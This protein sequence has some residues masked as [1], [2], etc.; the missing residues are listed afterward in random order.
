ML[1]DK[2]L[3]K[4]QSILETLGLLSARFGDKTL[5]A[6]DHFEADLCAI[7]VG[8]EGDRCRLVYFSTYGHAPGR[9]YVELEL[10]PTESTV[11]PF[12]KGGQYS[13]VDFETLV[14]L[15]AE[16]LSLRAKE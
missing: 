6:I 14:R 13:D 16:H 4:E 5:R 8:R 9:Y 15:V 12:V 1:S 2:P 10:P 11:S 7:S 3:V